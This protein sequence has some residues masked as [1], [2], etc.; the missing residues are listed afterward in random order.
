MTQ[1]MI[2]DL[3]E[4]VELDKENIEKINEAIVNVNT[5]LSAM[6]NG[7]DSG[8]SYDWIISNVDIYWNVNDNDNS[9]VNARS[10]MI[11][12]LTKL[13]D[14]FTS[15][16]NFELDV[17]AV[18]QAAEDKCISLEERIGSNQKI[19]DA[20]YYASLNET[21]DTDDDSETSDDDGDEDDDE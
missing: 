19:I 15:G 1:E 17:N 9:V 18:I 14:D 2:N 13:R 4:Q 10:E 6:K 8:H 21:E 16:G 3:E 7:E 11:G 5:A 20:S 12:D